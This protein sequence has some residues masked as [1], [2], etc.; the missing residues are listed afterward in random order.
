MEYAIILFICF[1]SLHFF[2]RRAK[3]ADPEKALEA[4]PKLTATFQVA[5]MG[6]FLKILTQK[7][8]LEEYALELDRRGKG[9]LVFGEA[10]DAMSFGF[11]YPI[12]WNAAN[13]G[14]T[15]ITV[16]VI[17]RATRSEFMAKRKFE[18]FKKFV[19]KCLQN[20]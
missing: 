5:D 2:L 4:A 11:F 9:Q 3:N 13:G 6:A 12:T 10:P 1:F 8:E 7:A 14:D 20:T 19:E 15:S 18:A 16:G 17:P